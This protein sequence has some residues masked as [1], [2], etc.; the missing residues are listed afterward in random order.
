MKTISEFV[1]LVVY[2]DGINLIETPIELQL[3][4][5]NLNNEFEMKDLGR[6]KLCLGLQIKHLTYGI[7]VHQSSYT[8]KVL[9][10][11]CT[12]EVR[13]LSN[14]MGFFSLD[15]NKDPFRPHEKDEEILGSE[16]PYLSGIGALM[17]LAN[18]QGQ[19]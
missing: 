12:D 14:M 2:V 15:V 17:Y 8:E 7:F 10:R 3:T 1:L 11:F 16:V 6:T 13:L 19:I 5:D 18:T 9:K 4:I